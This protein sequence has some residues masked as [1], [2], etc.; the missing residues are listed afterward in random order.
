MLSGGPVL[1]LPGVVEGVPGP[2]PD[3][4]PG[5]PSTA[6]ARAAGSYLAASR[7]GQPVE[8]GAADRLAPRR[9]FPVRWALPAERLHVP[10]FRL[11]HVPDDPVQ[12]PAA[13]A[14]ALPK[15]SPPGG[16]LPPVQGPPARP[17]QALEATALGILDRPTI[18]CGL[19]PRRP[20][21]RGGVPL[22]PFDHPELGGVIGSAEAQ[23]GGGDRPPVAGAVD[24]QGVQ[25]RLRVPPGPAPPGPVEGCG[26]RPLGSDLQEDFDQAMIRARLD[27]TAVFSGAPGGTPRLLS[28]RAENRVGIG[29]VR[30]G[31]GIER[32]PTLA[33]DGRALLLLV[34]ALATACA[35]L[36]SSHRQ[37]GSR[38]TDDRQDGAKVDSATTPPADRLV[39]GYYPTVR[40]ESGLLVMSVTFADGSS[41]ELVFPTRLGLQDVGF[42][43]LAGGRIGD[44]VQTIQYVHGD[45]IDVKGSGPLETYKG[46]DGSSV[47]LWQPPADFAIDCPYLIY[48]FGDWSAA[49]SSCPENLSQDERAVWAKNLKGTVA[50]NGFLVLDA[51][52]PL[53]LASSPGDTVE[54]A[55]KIWAHPP[56]AWPFFT[57]RPGNCDPTSPP[58]EED[59]RVMGDGTA[60]GFSRIGHG[61]FVD[62]CE[63]GRLMIQLESRTLAYAED[64]AAN[65]R[66]RNTHLLA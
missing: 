51:E 38:Q 7:G 41:T 32:R 23:T 6:A 13:A 57:F 21:L 20:E 16:L 27:R 19:H 36:A 49:A 24:E 11:D 56:G 52:L 53:E 35:G 12:V 34:V 42:Y 10:F 50:E 22:P 15:L 25:R 3:E 55:P 37:F 61:W 29:A 64:V 59:V 9:P 33:K 60:V 5:G 65:L 2:S 63:D 62:W 1:D 8:D 48:R 17:E 58:S 4:V 18:G 14:R 44:V 45:A 66:A 54:L 43:G 31:R 46:Y 39:G 40:E 30:S 28:P 26:E 47:E